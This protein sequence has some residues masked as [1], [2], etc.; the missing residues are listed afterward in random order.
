MTW[1]SWGEITT[2]FW[3]EEHRPL[4]WPSGKLLPKGEWVLQAQPWGQAWLA[5]GQG[6][7]GGWRQA[8][9]SALGRLLLQPRLSNRDKIYP[10]SQKTEKLDKIY[11]KVSD[12]GQQAARTVTLEGK[13]RVPQTEHRQEVQRSP[14]LRRQPE[15]RET[16]MA[17]L[18]PHPFNSHVGVQ[19]PGLRVTIFG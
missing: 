3:K 2:D 13:D 1:R 4:I 8:K 19:P 15:S 11:G 9:L 12:V 7:K 17:M 14:R 5:G 6:G 10:T 18:C 16:V